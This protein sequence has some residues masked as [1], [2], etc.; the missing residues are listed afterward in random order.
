MKKMNNWIWLKDY[1][2]GYVVAEARKTYFSG[3]AS[4]VKISADCRYTLYVNGQY[5]GSGPVSAGSDFLFEKVD[6]L[7]YDT[8][9]I[10]QTGEIDIKVEVTSIPTALCQ[11]TLGT[12]GLFFEAYQGDS[13]ICKA[14]ESWDIRVIGSKIGA[15][16]IDYTKK[17]STFEKAMAVDN[18][19]MLEKSPLLHLVRE[20]IYPNGKSK[21]TVPSGEK[22][23]LKVDF[24]KIYSA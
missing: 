7:Y 5:L 20:N 12:P 18:P 2:E 13:L 11:T 6:C 8:Y 16:Y 1:K 24:D 9:E 10:S 14:D 21:I 23:T 3:E 15:T 17:E 22:A 19:P 4:T